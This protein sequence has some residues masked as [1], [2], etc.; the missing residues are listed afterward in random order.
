MK[1][2]KIKWCIKRGY[3]LA[4]FMLHKNH[5]MKFFYYFFILPLVFIGFSCKKYLEQKPNLTQTSPVT[6]KDAQALLDYTRQMNLSRTPSAMESSADDYFLLSD[7]YNSVSSYLQEAYTWAYFIYNNP[8][9]WSYCYLPIYTSNYCLEIC[10]NINPTTGNEKLWKNVHGS[11]LYFRSFYF[12]QLLMAYSKAYDASTS[13]TDL[14][15]VLRLNSDFEEPSVRGSVAD[16]Y[17]QITSDLK[18]AASELPDLP[19]HVLR[20]SKCAAY[21]LLARSYLLMNQFDSSLKYSNLSLSLNGNL[22]DYNMTPC[23]TCDVN[24]L[25][26]STSAIFRRFNSETLFYSEMNG[27]VTA[28]S[29][30]RGLVDTVLYNTYLENDL[31]KTAF[32]TRSGNYYRYKGSYAQSTSTFFTGITTA[33]MYLVSAESYA[34]IGNVSEALKQ[35]NKILLNRM[36]GGTFEPVTAANA[37][38]ALSRILLERR[39]E[40]VFRG[41]RW[42]DLKRYNKSGANITL[43][44]IIDGNTYTLLPDANYYALPLPTDIVNITG[45]PQ[46][47]Q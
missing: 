32:F 33:E 13:A 18:I 25:L 37:E 7:S 4:N 29:T 20:P 42:A 1:Q 16:G 23:S 34:R 3:S 26:S 38:D 28:H 5:L 19:E 47:P 17:S 40:L 46:N 14:G 21:S 10:N 35:L 36:R 9:D 31:R 45:M 44:R 27:N 24:S 41:L 11:A 30:S 15:I 6:L 8:N 2:V 12:L 43:K 22:I 39:K